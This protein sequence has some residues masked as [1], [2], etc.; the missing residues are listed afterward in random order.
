MPFPF[1]RALPLA[2]L[3]ACSAYAVAGTLPLSEQQLSKKGSA[4]YEFAQEQVRIRFDD[5]GWDSGV[6]ILPPEGQK[7]WDMSGAKIFAADIENLSPDRQ[8]RLTAHIS[9][10]SREEKNFSEVSSGVAVNPGETRTL[11]LRIPHRSI[12]KLPKGPRGPRTLE[13]DKINW[14][15]FYMQWPFEKKQDALVDARI[16]NLRLIGEPDTAAHV[17]EENFFPFIDVYGQYRHGEWK[18]KILTDED[19]VKNHAEELIELEADERPKEWNQYGGWANGPQLEATGNFRTEKYDGK[20]WLV[21]PE[22]RLFFSHG[23]D[24]LIASTDATSSKNRPEWF[25]FETNGEMIPFN[26]L[27]L[28]KKYG[29]EDFE[30]EFYENLHKRLQHWGMNTIGNWGHRNMIDIGK[31]PY[32]LQLMDFDRSL[33]R[34]QG[35]KLKFYD[36]FDPAYIEAMKNLIPNAAKKNPVVEKSLTDPLCIGYFIDNELNYGNRGRQILGDAVLKSPATQAAKQEFVKDLK[37]KYTDIAALNKAWQTDYASWDALLEGTEFVPNSDGFRAD[38]NAFFHKAVD[39]YFRLGREAIKSV[40]P[41][42]LYLG[43]RFISTDAV[44]KALYDASERYCD[45]LTVNVYAHSVANIGDADFPDMPVIVGEFHF[46]IYDRGMFA[47]GVIAAGTT[48]EERALAYTRFLQG[49][50]SHPKIVGTHWFQFR[51]QPLT[52][53][54]DGEG[55]A[56]GFVD[57]ADTPYK[58]MTEASREVG[59]HMYEYRTRGTLPL[60]MDGSDAASSATDAAPASAN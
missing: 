5:P 48:Q 19:L 56:I 6:R 58:E 31:T 15:E 9:S 34:I 47:P 38:S 35:G 49:A 12:Y 23:I 32:T 40:A 20:W 27:N 21:D 50:L 22:G 7:Y 28:Q 39:Q 55:Y 17:S 18:E 51:D 2:L 36:V 24:V 60:S 33:P 59:E 42:R 53:R 46:G 52:G 1:H 8:L 13:T 26:A 57:V 30:I 45:I 3:L 54:W 10:G 29:K 41:H 25:D 43:S 16:S 37:A 14:I 11:T 4:Q 44:R